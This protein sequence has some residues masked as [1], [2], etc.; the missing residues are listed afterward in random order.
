ML[1]TGFYPYKY[2]GSWEKVSET[3]LPDK[4]EFSV[5]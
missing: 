2:I 3:S 4:N 5:G 1:R